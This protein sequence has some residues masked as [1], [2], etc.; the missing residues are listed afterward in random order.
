MMY[1]LLR[2]QFSSDTAKKLVSNPQDRTGPARELI[3]GF[4]GKLQSYYFA[5]GE[6]DGIGIVEMPDTVS[7]TAASML[8][9]ST[10]AFSRFETTQL[11]TAQEAEAAMKKAQ[12]K[13]GVYKAPNA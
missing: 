11:V 7:A 4:G 2:W 5:L 10:G 6:Y 13:S 8:A 1:F 9:A 3:E 12:A